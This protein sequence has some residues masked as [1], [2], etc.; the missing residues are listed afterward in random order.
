[1]R[2]KIYYIDNL[3]QCADPDHPD[4][5]E[6]N[7]H[8]LGYGASPDEAIGHAV[9]ETYL[10]Q[11]EV[12]INDIISREWDEH[13]PRGSV[14]RLSRDMKDHET[15]CGDFA[16]GQR[17]VLV[18]EDG[19]ILFRPAGTHD[20]FGF[21]LSAEDYEPCLDCPPEGCDGDKPCEGL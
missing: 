14:V 3:Y 11:D 19:E 6:D 7:P 13:L 15:G 9:R 18:D 2:L 21:Y 5:T 1:M 12:V 8:V 10:V 20:G 17:G 4:H 16:K